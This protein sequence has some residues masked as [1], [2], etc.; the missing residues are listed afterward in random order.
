MSKGILVVVSGFSGSGKGT[1][2]KR[3]MEKYD[4]Y[5]LSVSV[6]TRNPRPGEKDGEA[7]FFRTKEE[8]EQL[9]RE[10]GLI[11]YAQYVEN[12]YGT[13]RKYVEEQLS[14]GKDVILEIEIQG[15][16]KIR[17]KFPDTLLV[18]VCPPS[19]EELKNRLVGRG[20]E[21]LDVINGRL[22]R[23]VEE[24]RGMD[25]YDYLMIWRN[26][27]IHFMRPSG[28]S[29]C[30]HPG[31]MILYPGSRKKRKLFYKYQLTS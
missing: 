27:L 11:E 17:E 23:A 16:M 1:V 21:T 5:A 19:M 8:F 12:Y 30:V 22:R 15:A 14:A 9:I 4:N 18:F 20:T 2:M 3:L 28:V 26:V 29:A 13:P 25:K 6:T 31:I 7:Y 24:S 10:D